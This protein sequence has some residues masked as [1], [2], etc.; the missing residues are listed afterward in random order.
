MSYLSYPSIS[1][2]G[3][4]VVIQNN[5]KSAPLVTSYSSYIQVPSSNMLKSTNGTTTSTITQTATNV[6]II[7]NS[8]TV[9][10]PSI[11]LN[12]NLK[13][14][15]SSSFFTIN[16]PGLN[17][18]FV[19]EN[20]T[21]EVKLIAFLNSNTTSFNGNGGTW[22]LL[23]GQDISRSQFPNL[24]SRFGTAYGSG[25]G[26]TTFNLPNMNGL[27]P[28]Q[29]GSCNVIPNTLNYQV[30]PSK[31]SGEYEH[32]LNQGEMP[33]HN[34]EDNHTHIDDHIHDVNDPGHSHPWNSPPTSSMGGSNYMGPIWGK[35]PTGG[36]LYTGYS[37]T[38]V[39]VKSKSASGFGTNTQSKSASGF[40]ST[41]G[42]SGGSVP[43][44]VATA[45]LGLG[46]YYIFAN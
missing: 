22:F 26:S 37:Y 23:N 29:P 38:G 42:N 39:T 16:N 2:I 18:S 30:K 21:G 19:G 34:H 24:F 35:N 28:T 31:V 14:E 20:I 27:Y 11:N 5:I 12:N 13:V 25:N 45:T 8:F 1:D 41:T 15:N 43:H 10:S 6:G 4:V 7:S 33:A 44:N 36:T 9:T 46:Y 32:R 40:G 17:T 3:D